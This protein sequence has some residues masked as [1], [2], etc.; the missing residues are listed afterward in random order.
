ML[1]YGIES[2]IS[3]AH[4]ILP[5]LLFLQDILKITF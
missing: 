3:D 5:I 4:K 1:K 2:Q